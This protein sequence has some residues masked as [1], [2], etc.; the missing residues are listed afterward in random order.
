MVNV[1]AT[2]DDNDSLA[3]SL[4]GTDSSSFSID[5]EGLISFNSAPNY[6]S[7]SSYQIIVKVTDGTDTT[8]KVV[9]INIIDVD[10]APTFSLADNLSVDENNTDVVTISANDEDNDSLS[11]SLS[12]TDASSLS[13]S[14]S[15]E[16]TFNS[17]PDYETKN[18]YSLIVSVSDGN[19]NTQKNLTISISNVLEVTQIGSEIRPG[20][21]AGWSTSSLS[22][23]NDGSKLGI[24]SRH[25][26]EGGGVGCYSG[27]ARVYELSGGNWTQFGSD[28]KRSADNQCGRELG[29]SVSLNDDGTIAAVG[30]PG[31]S[32]DAS[33]SVEVYESSG[34]GWQLKGSTIS[35]STAGTYT[36]ILVG[37]DNSGTKLAIGDKENGTTSGF[38]EFESGDW[39][40]KSGPNFTAKSFSF[41]SD[42]SIL[43]VGTSTSAII[44]DISSG[45]WSI[46]SGQDSFTSSGWSE[47]GFP[48]TGT[49]VSLSSDGSRLVIGHP[50]SDCVQNRYQY[51]Y[52]RIYNWTGSSWQLEKELR[53]DDYDDCYGLVTALSSDGSK[54]AVGSPTDDNSLGSDSGS[55]K[56]Y[57]RLNNN[58]VE[59]NEITPSSSILGIRGGLFGRSLS[60]SSDGTK[61]AVGAPWCG[62]Y[63]SGCVIVY[64]IQ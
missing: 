33:G 35:S 21:A 37:L 31:D 32:G 40:R 11:F 56:L 20:G 30:I 1:L 28:I 8:S 50:S 53:A 63:T 13:I 17:A 29:F 27:R 10:E 60:M 25:Y 61:L 16:I 2:D 22:F 44:Y 52:V 23:S 64:S 15:G 54:L 51:G 47:E 5:T 18:S 42:G 49:N 3:Y 48:Y 58:W 24:G 41:S 46:R 43:A 34:S 57:E 59:S 45:S 4:E 62:G 38:Y 7:T 6:E 39:A 9:N 26:G 55:V 14:G 12:G 36:G 19:N